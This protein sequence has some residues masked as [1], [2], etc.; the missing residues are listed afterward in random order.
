[1]TPVPLAHARRA[2]DQ[3]GRLRTASEL[4]QY[5]DVT[6]PFTALT[7]QTPCDHLVGE[8]PRH[9]LLAWAIRYR[10][11][12]PRVPS[13]SAKNIW[14]GRWAAMDA[15]RRARLPGRKRGMVS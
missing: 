8:C 14:A 12:M 7:V 9:D 13:N 10:A 1:M 11:D 4:Y 5:R 6:G 15:R 2:E 3:I